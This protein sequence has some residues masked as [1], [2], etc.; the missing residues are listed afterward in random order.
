MRIGKDDNDEVVV[1]DGAGVTSGSVAGGAFA[2]KDSCVNDFVRARDIATGIDA[3]VA[4]A[5][6]GIAV[7]MAGGQGFD[8]RRFEIEGSGVRA[9]PEGIEAMGGLYGF[10][11][12]VLRKSYGK[13]VGCV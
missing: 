13:A 11:F 9:A 5:L 1:I 12:T 2:L 6:V 4:A 7:N 3:R 8:A 10:G